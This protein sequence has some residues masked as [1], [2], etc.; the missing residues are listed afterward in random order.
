M[1]NVHESNYEQYNEY[2]FHFGLDRS[3]SPASRPASITGS[4]A[5]AFKWQTAPAG[6]SGSARAPA[7]VARW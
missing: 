5:H 3:I 6:F 1:V 7:I 2:S 4:L